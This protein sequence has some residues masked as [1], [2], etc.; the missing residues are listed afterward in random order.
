MPRIL[1]KLYAPFVDVRSDLG[2]RR[3]PA[4]EMR[5][6]SR[7]A[8]MRVRETDCLEVHESDRAVVSRSG[9]GGSVVS[10]QRLRADLQTDVGQTRSRSLPS[11]DVTGASASRSVCS[12]RTAATQKL[13]DQ[14]HG[15]TAPRAQRLPTQQPHTNLTSYNRLV[16]HDLQH[17][18]RDM[19]STVRTPAGSADPDYSRL[20]AIRSPRGRR[21]RCALLVR[22]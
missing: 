19:V 3:N 15:L 12:F 11:S 18:P 1:K 9:C 5:R 17:E 13:L 22:F 6:E 8:G 4:L 16:D 2:R 21:L 10:K 7:F 20:T 14:Q